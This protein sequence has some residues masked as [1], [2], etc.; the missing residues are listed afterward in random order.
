MQRPLRC[1][2]AALFL[3]CAL[4]APASAQLWPDLNEDIPASGGGENDAAL[5]IAIGDY[6]AVEDI[7]GATD[8]ARDWYSWLTRGRGVPSERVKLLQNNYGTLEK[9]RK[10]IE[11]AAS[12]TPSG[13]TLWVVFI[14]HGAPAPDGKDGVLVGFDAQQDP[15]SLYA[16]SL[17]QSQLLELA[18]R[19]RQARTVLLV[20]ACFSGKGGSG[21][22]LATGLQPLIPLKETPGADQQTVVLSAGTGDQFAGP[23]PGAQR[24][25][26]SYLAL[27]ALRGWAD[28]DK[29]GQVSA[30]EVQNYTTDALRTLLVGRDQTPQAYGPLETPLSPATGEEGPR[31]GDIA[32]LLSKEGDAGG[33]GPAVSRGP[34]RPA[35]LSGANSLHLMANLGLGF[36][37]PDRTILTGVDGK[38]EDAEGVLRTGL[39]VGVLGVHRWIEWAVGLG[40]GYA[41][42]PNA[43]KLNT[44]AAKTFSGFEGRASLGFPLFSWPSPDVFPDSW[45]TLS[46]GVVAEYFDE[47]GGGLYVADTFYLDCLWM[48]RVEGLYRLTNN[49]YQPPLQLTFSVGVQTGR[50]EVCR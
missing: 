43:P 23:L 17:P 22:A 34:R 14:G 19:G 32:I 44:V 12:T 9:M 7:P 20:D 49:D 10:G 6:A 25:A 33:P 28:K 26:F 39:G 35:F 38:A 15:E 11:D 47:V 18:H 1:A 37:A 50:D 42:D 27:G 21:G 40:Y 31:L 8:N 5:I 13:G 3:V 48:G 30:T 41:N 29:D 46:A 2:L 36:G 24:P 4:T 45:L 16:R